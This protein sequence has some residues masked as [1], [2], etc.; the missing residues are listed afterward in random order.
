M[1]HVRNGNVFFID[2]L[3]FLK[4]DPVSLHFLT[5]IPV[6]LY[7]L[8]FSNQRSKG[9]SFKHKTFNKMC[10]VTILLRIQQSGRFSKIVTI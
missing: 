7:L 3:K 9:M 1:L 4:S 8:Q 2:V 6:L 10:F 5:L